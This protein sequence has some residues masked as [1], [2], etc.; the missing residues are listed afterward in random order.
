GTIS[1]GE[2]EKLEEEATKKGIFALWQGSK[3]EVESVLRS[4]CDKVL[5]DPLCDKDSVRRRA[6]GL[7]IVGDIYKNVA[8]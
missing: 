2:K 4:V 6:E 5:S 7:K 8:E 3:L 1:A